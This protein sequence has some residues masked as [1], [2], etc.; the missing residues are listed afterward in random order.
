MKEKVNFIVNNQIALSILI[1]TKG[2][3]ALTNPQP[4]MAQTAPPPE[5]KINVN[6]AMGTLLVL[7][8]LAQATLYVAL[9]PFGA[10]LTITFIQK[11][12]SR[13]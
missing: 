8:P 6:N 5:V 1:S 3:I 10:F 12:M 13:V 2:A 7:N 9:L 4:I 11:I